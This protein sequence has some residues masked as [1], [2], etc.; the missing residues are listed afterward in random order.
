MNLLTGTSKSF[1]LTSKNIDILVLWEST[2]EIWDTLKTTHKRINIFK[3]SK[4]LELTK[5]FE[6]LIM[7]DD[8]M[9]DDF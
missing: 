5:K 7:E 3:V 4:L 6:I 9:S 2:K 8:E 1:V